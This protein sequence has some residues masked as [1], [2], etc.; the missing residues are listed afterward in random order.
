MLQCSCSESVIHVVFFSFVCVVINKTTVQLHAQ[1]YMSL[2]KPS[3]TS[4]GAQNLALQ[5]EF[6][7]F[8]TRVDMRLYSMKAGMCILSED[9]SNIFRLIR[10]CTICNMLLQNTTKSYMGFCANKL[11]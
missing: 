8:R 3:V 4:V 2:S 10:S 11:S 9:L 5:P 1:Y 6:G 7:H